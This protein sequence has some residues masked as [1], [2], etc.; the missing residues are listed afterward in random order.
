MAFAM[1]TSLLAGSLVVAGVGV[2]ISDGGGAFGFC[3]LPNSCF[4]SGVDGKYFMRYRNKVSKSDNKIKQI[5]KDFNK[6][7]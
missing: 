1:L 6:I 5:N 7:K 2:D 4:R 3:T